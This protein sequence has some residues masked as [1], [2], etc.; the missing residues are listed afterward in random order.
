LHKQPLIHVEGGGIALNIA[1]IV[2]GAG[3][4]QLDDVIE[5]PLV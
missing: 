5:V 2:I 3:D 1:Q 4:Q